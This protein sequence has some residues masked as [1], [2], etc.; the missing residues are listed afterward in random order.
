MKGTRRGFTLV[1][2]L[3]VVAIIAVLAGITIVAVAGAVKSARSSRA[4]SMRVVLEQGISAFYAQEGQWPKVIEQKAASMNKTSYEFTP[5][6]ADKIFQEV[7]GKAFGKGG[8]RSALLDVTG[9]YVCDSSKVG[10]GGRGCFDN[11]KN[12]GNQVTY[13]KGQG[14][15]LGRD[16]ADAVKKTDKNAQ[17]SINRM[18]FGYQGTEEG[19]FRRFKIIYNSKTDSVTVSQ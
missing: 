5:A 15:R 11:H 18:A 19:L 4:E 7:V 12:L 9:L 10:N 13:C 14:C 17:L 2:L 1:E 6:E 8:R 16:F 3:V